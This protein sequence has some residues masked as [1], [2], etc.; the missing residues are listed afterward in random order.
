MNTENPAINLLALA[1]DADAVWFRDELAYAWRTAHDE[2][3]VAYDA[4]RDSPG[5]TGYAAY[6][7]AQDC[8]DQAQDVLASNPRVP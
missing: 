6:R 4:W 5:S 1:A 3:V 7:A 2:A 8:A